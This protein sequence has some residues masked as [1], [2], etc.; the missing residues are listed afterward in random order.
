MACRLSREVAQSCYLSLVPSTPYP[1]YFNPDID[2]L[3]SKPPLDP[4]DHNYPRQDPDEPV[5]PF[6]D[7]STD[8]SL[9]RFIVIEHSYWSYRLSGNVS[10][11]MKELRGFK[12]IEEI[13]FL[14]PSLE[15]MIERSRRSQADFPR[16]NPID[17]PRSDLKARYERQ[18]PIYNACPS[19]WIPGF[20]ICPEIGKFDQPYQQYGVEDSLGQNRSPLNLGSFDKNFDINEFHIKRRLPRI[21]QLII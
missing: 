2:I 18:A 15:E 11:P 19:S 16:L 5:L 14:M 21:S 20:R 7:P 8:V 4:V 9:V 1:V 6:M 3:Y 12:S 17:Y 10:C 13:F